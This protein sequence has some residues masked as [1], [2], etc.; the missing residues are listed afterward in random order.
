MQFPESNPMRGLFLTLASVVVALHAFGA[1]HAA[2]GRPNIVYI[3]TD[4]LGYGDVQALN[5]ERGRIPTPE[6]DRMCKEGMA[7]TDCHASSSVCTPSRY[8]I[9]TG[10]YHWRSRWQSGALSGDAAPLLPRDRTTV[11]ELLQQNGYATCLIG[12]WHLGMAF[13]KSDYT[14][15]ITDGPLQ[16]GFD[17]FFGIA[18]SLDMQPYAYI[19][20]D[21]FTQVPSVIKNCAAPD[22]ERPGPAAPDFESIDVL[23]ELTRRATDHIRAA[24]DSE[25]PFFLYLALTSPH[26]P[27]VPT[28][29]WQGKSGLG[30]YGDFVMQT[31]WSV[32]QIMKAIDDSGLGDN[33]LIFFT[34]D[35]GAAPYGGVPELAKEGHFSSAQFRGYKSDVWDGGHRV[36]FLVRWTGKIKPGSRSD[37]LACLSDLMATCADILQTKLPDNAGE[38]SVSL[39][40]VLLDTDREPLRDSLVHHSG[41]KGRFAIRQGHWKLALCPGSGGWGKPN[42]EEALAEGLPPVQLY[43]LHEDIGERVNIEGEHADTVSRLVKLLEKI[44]TEGRS[45]PGPQQTN[46]AQVSIW[47]GKSSSK[48]LHR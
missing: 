22:F 4:D 1:S 17:H 27:I 5:P 10:R 11:A 15:P 43:N 9:L 34:S 29:E 13:D 38:D 3:L 19:E 14:K 40:P 12:K 7:F 37:Q 24:K 21:R 26:T 30:S 31:D 6:L 36:P 42:D 41:G 23:P 18:A 20:N 48:T 28:K 25:K 45:T 44:V 16:H 35:N 32:G 46:D 39:L 47:R 33:T 8:S 2:T